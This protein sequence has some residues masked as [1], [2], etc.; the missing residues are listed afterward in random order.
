MPD[1]GWPEMIILAIV[2]AF[3]VGI[4]LLVLVIAKGA[5]K[6]S[7]SQTPPYQLADGIPA[8]C[9]SGSAVPAAHGLSATR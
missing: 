4:T 5:S 3:V 2:I 6:P 7:P 8:A 9:G 1:L